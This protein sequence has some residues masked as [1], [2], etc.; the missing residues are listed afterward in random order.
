MIAGATN[1]REEGKKNTNC[2]YVMASLET[3]LYSNP[4]DNTGYYM[5][6]HVGADIK[7]IDNHMRNSSYKTG[8]IKAPLT[9]LQVLNEP[10]YYVKL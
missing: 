5:V 10:G 8:I 1:I 3:T 2:N 4:N 7:F 9:I 6:Y